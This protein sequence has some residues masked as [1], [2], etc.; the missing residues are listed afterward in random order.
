M[1]A[2]AEPFAHS[3]AWYRRR[4]AALAEVTTKGGITGWGEASGPSEL[5]AVVGRDFGLF[6]LRPDG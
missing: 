1:A 4:C 5:T 2:L 3:Q 6:Y